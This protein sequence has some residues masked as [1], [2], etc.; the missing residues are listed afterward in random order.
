MKKVKTESS[1]YLFDNLNELQKEE[2]LVMQ[3]AIDML[4]NVYAPYSNFF[5]GA[6]AMTNSGKI[7]G[8]CNQEN[9]SYPLCVCGERV[10]LFNAGANEPTTPIKLLAIVCHNPNKRV[11]KP[12]SPCGACRQVISEFE[13]RHDQS[14][15]ILLKGD[16]ETIVKLESGSELLP[17]SFDGTYL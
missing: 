16:T 15:P 9:A 1:Y 3:K 4:Q 12:V 10:A 5:V 7:Y 13:M 2:Q 8:G 11:E 14:F 17:F 6:A